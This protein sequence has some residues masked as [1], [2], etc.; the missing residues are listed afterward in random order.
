MTTKQSCADLAVFGG[1]PLFDFPRS[2]SSLVPPKLEDFLDY[3]RIFYEAHQFTNNGPLV[4]ML[5]KRL[6]GFHETARCVSFC[7]GFWALVLAMKCLAL[8]GRTEVIMPSLTYRRMADVV[9]WA[10][11]VPRFCEVN[12]KTL[13]VDVEAVKSLLGEDTALILGVHPIVNC[14]DA[15]GLERLSAQTG[16]PL[17]FD[18]VE[19]VYETVDGRKVGS[20]GRAECFSMHASKLLNGF[21]GGYITTDDEQLADKLVRM[22]G[23]G[24]YTPDTVY[25]LGMNA[26]LNEVHAAMALA[27]MNNLD[28]QVSRNL[29]CY[30]AYQRELK[31]MAGI[32]LVEFDESEKC[33]YK[34]I[35]VEL[36]ET[37][38]LTRAETLRLLNAENIL[39][40]AYYAPPLHLGPRSKAENVMLPITEFLAER[41]MLLPCGHFVDEQ[42]V[43]EI[44]ELLRFISAEAVQL[45]RELVH[46]C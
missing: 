12:E 44:A 41:Y 38:P 5:E 40:R 19:S 2:T 7:S 22:R 3:S 43:I 6:A 29:A 46:G 34:N 15:S 37:W 42:D 18:A 32:R 10:G 36:D 20:F 28:E 33:S 30:R 14:C 13:A 35:L 21:E 9:S 24:F 17:L 16:V 26:K 27:G 4:Q 25:D 11:L 1:L 8:P 23:F 31:G 45:S 39:A